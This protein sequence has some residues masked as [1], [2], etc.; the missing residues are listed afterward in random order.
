MSDQFMNSI[1]AVRRNPAATFEDVAQLGKLALE[2]MQQAFGPPRHWPRSTWG[3]YAGLLGAMC[4]HPEYHAWARTSGLISKRIVVWLILNVF[5]VKKRPGYNDYLI[6]R[7][8]LLGDEETAQTILNQAKREDSAGCTACWALRSL[9][10]QYPEFQ[11]RFGGLIPKAN[12]AD[13]L[14]DAPPDADPDTV[15]RRA[16]WIDKLRAE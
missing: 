6:I 9:C 5:G 1:I 4:D 13:M 16:E 14:K 8:M 10:Q 2:Y 11:E 7:W 12:P 15:L 3:P